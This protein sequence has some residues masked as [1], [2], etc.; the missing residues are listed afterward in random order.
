MLEPTQAQARR[1]AAEVEVLRQ[2]GPGLS[3][4]WWCRVGLGLTD[5]QARRVLALLEES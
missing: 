1:L 2:C 4:R 5:R 3:P